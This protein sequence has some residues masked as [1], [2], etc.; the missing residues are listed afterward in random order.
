MT[1][2]LVRACLLMLS[3]VLLAF[4]AP[5]SAQVAPPRIPEPDRVR[6]VEAFRLADHIGDRVWRGQRRAPFAVL[7]VTHE[8]EF[9]IRHP[10]PDAD[11]T[12][13]GYDPLLR[14][15]VYT[16]GRK[17]SP[18]LLATFPAVGGVSTVVIGQAEN[19]GKDSTAWVVTVLH[20]HF[21]QLQDSQADFYQD[22]ERLGL[23][24]GDTTGMWMLNFGFPYAAPEVSEG[25]ARASHLLAVAV[26]APPAEL[27]AR[28]RAYLEARDELRQALAVDDY[29]YLA[30]QLW[31]E[32]VARYTELRVAEL[33]ARRY[34][35]TAAFRALPDYKAYLQIAEQ[36]RAS[37]LC[38]LDAARLSEN[39]RV[40]FY[41][42]GAGEALLLD[43]A[44]PR[45]RRHYLAER[46]DTGRYFA[47]RS[48]AAR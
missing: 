43:R 25:F 38:E 9:L 22:V 5:A 48:R 3:L 30:F 16:R 20:E 33:A 28:T 36:L 26:R 34:R 37:V 41:A 27:R 7:L 40:A 32:G 39:Q 29:K 12:S 47:A 31:K 17:L 15:Q 10:Q 11:F 13:A 8:R 2:R 35:P 6:L 24:R 14:S 4:A 46:F 21:H 19:T 45:W 23:A 44:H 1:T 18:K 42:F